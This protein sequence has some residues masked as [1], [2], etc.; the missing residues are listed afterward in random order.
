MSEAG[1]D[2]GEKSHEPTAKKLDDAR[3]KGNIARS[4]DVLVAASYL[5]LWLAL[6]VIG[7]TAV[8]DLGT[9]L[10]RQFDMAALP[11]PGAAASHAMPRVAGTVASLL[12]VPLAVVALV[13]V[14]Q[15]GIVFTG[16]NLVPKLDRISPL[17]GAQKK[18]GAAG[19]FE[20]GKSTLKLV[21]ISTAFAIWL[22][23]SYDEM[24]GLATADARALALYLGRLTIALLSLAALI[25]CVMAVVDLFWQRFDHRRKLRMSYK[26]LRDETKESEGDPTQRAQ[27]QRRAREIASNQMMANVPDADVIL[28]NPTQIAVALGWDRSPGSAPVCLA[29][30]SGEI[31]AR[32]REVAAENGIPIYRDVPTA[33]RLHADLPVGAE[34]PEDTYRA[35]AAALRFAEQ[36]RKKAS[37]L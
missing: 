12:V 28:V 21:I 3:R 33:R 26:D 15:R 2:S 34:I 17:K 35:I 5:G 10:A 29:K 19:L 23:A 32:I 20:F 6:L 16:G 36:M 25:A 7:A 22:A 13:L 11:R 14:A 1:E 9:T 24:I 30:G 27:R 18:F 31:A 37:V 8:E 4:Q